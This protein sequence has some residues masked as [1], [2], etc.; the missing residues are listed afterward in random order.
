MLRAIEQRSITGSPEQVRARLLA[1][2]EAHGVDDFV[3]LTITY[4][5]KDRIRSHALLAEA[6][7]L[8]QA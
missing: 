7:G 3:I 8:E 2:G 6:M 4:D 5:Q 1:L